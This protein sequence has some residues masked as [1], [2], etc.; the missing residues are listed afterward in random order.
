MPKRPD[1]RETVLL[2][3]EL[4]KRI[5][6]HRKVSAR[7]L[8]EQL[9]DHL[10]RDLRTVQR[11]LDML[12]AEF[13]IERDDSSKPY[14]YRWKERSAGLSMPLLS[15]QES[16]VLALAEAHLRNLLPTGVMR[17]MSGFFSQ[18]S[19]QLTAGAGRPAHEWL[20]K[21]RVVSTTQPLLAP[22]LAPGVFEVVSEA[23]Y[24]NRWLTLDYKNAAGARARINV[25]P[26]GLAQQGPRLYLVC[27]Y[28][29]FDN[30]R[31]LALHRIAAATVSAQ[32]F[33]RPA[34]FRLERYD[35]DGRFGFG[36]GRRIEIV[37]RIESGAGQHLLE[38]PL[39]SD[40]HVRPVKGGY[41]IRATVVDSAQLRWWLRGFGEAVLVVRPEGLLN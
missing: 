15:E 32:T 21:V 7:E 28:E 8:H 38:S 37:F 19:R 18:A 25:M 22:K 14:G 34:G 16:L 27:R 29:G 13:D 41:E 30:E 10:A 2:A 39:S 4:L 17:S 24:W 26:L 36:D 3:L 23:L 12:A 6:K 33:Q 40:Q 11:Q 5:P 1:T 20:G 31:S 35:D 9:P